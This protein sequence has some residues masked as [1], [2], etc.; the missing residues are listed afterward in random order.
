MVLMLRLPVFGCGRVAKF[1]RPG[2]CAAGPQWA[3]VRDALGPAPGAHTPW[4][5]DGR[6]GGDAISRILQLMA[7]MLLLLP[8]PV[9][10]TTFTIA[11][12]MTA[13]HCPFLEMRELG[14]MGQT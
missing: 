11:L 9:H 5:L 8:A 1:E 10:D 3:F 4:T 13:L 14:P 12:L 2:G 7:S 6:R